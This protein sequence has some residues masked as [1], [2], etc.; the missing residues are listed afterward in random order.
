MTVGFLHRLRK[1]N[2]W[3]TAFTAA[4][5]LVAGLQNYVAQTH[6]HSPAEVSAAQVG[7][8]RQVTA[9]IKLGTHANLGACLLC[10]IG[11]HGGTALLHSVNSV[12]GSALMVFLAAPAAF[13]V[14][15]LAGVSHHWQ[16][17]GPPS[18]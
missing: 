16:S 10:Q 3:R 8:Y 17:R 6:F 13:L 11:L 12:A 14:K 5:L 2:A 15:P 9:P 18:Y 1:P 4:M 7:D